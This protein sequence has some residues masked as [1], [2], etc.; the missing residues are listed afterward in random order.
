MATPAAANRDANLVA[1]LSTRKFLTE[2]FSI[3][4]S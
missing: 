3:E 4:E 2:A 1:P